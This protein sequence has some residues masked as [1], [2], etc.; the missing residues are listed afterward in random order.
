MR[1]SHTA[2]ACLV[3]SCFDPQDVDGDV[4]VSSARPL[5]PAQHE[6]PAPFAPEFRSRAPSTALPEAGLL[7]RQSS[8]NV[9]L[10]ISP[11]S[12]F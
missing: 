2:A 10:W 7:G 3:V 9:M 6:H 8:R 1:E 4:R 12:V 11:N 5:D